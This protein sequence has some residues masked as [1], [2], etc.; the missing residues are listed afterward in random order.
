MVLRKIP[1]ESSENINTIVRKLIGYKHI[2]A[3]ESLCESNNNT[4]QNK[5]FIKPL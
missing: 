5:H 2:F 3:C 4:I 1:L